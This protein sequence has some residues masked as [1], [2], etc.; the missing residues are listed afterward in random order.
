MIHR[1][2]ETPSDPLYVCARNIYLSVPLRAIGEEDT[3]FLHVGVHLPLEG[4]H[5]TLDD[6]LH[7]VRELR[8]HLLLET[9]K[10]KGAE[11]FVET[12]DD[13]NSLFFI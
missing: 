3:L 8:L 5:V 11:H 13:E 1:A 2:F 9:T 7:L 10:Q 4:G 12:T 6:I